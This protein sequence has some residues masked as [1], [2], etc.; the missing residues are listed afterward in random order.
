KDSTRIQEA[1]KAAIAAG[2]SPHAV[3]A[4]GHMPSDVFLFSKLP[5]ADQEALLRNASNEE[6][7]RYFHHAHK[8]VRFKM[9]RERQPVQAAPSP[10][11][12]SPP[13]PRPAAPAPAA[14]SA[15]PPPSRPAPPRGRTQVDEVLRQSPLAPPPA[16]AWPPVPPPTFSD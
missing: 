2:Y 13:A 8:D 1:R 14:Q 4:I 15:T 12:S 16:Q 11:S 3:N 5:N 6:Y 9:G 10:A 7:A